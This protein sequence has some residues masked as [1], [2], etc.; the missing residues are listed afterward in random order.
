MLKYTCQRYVHN[1][2]ANNNVMVEGSVCSY[3]ISLEV[4]CKWL[5][6]TVVAMVTTPLKAV[7][8]PTLCTYYVQ[9]L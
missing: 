6:A 5:Y 9:K 7:R 2:T 4:Q 1:N 8:M 3:D